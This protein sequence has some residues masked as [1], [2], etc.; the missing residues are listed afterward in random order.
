MRCRLPL[1]KTYHLPLEGSALPSGGRSKKQGPGWARRKEGGREGGWESTHQRKKRHAGAH[2]RPANHKLQHPSRRRVNRPASSHPCA[3]HWPTLGHPGP[4]WATLDDPCPPT[5]PAR[6]Q[7]AHIT[8]PPKPCRLFAGGKGGERRK[9][10]NRR[11]GHC[12]GHFRGQWT[13]SSS[14]SSRRPRPRSE[15]KVLPRLF[16]CW[17]LLLAFAVGFRC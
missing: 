9:R 17:P 10:E 14:S 15:A 5:P 8:I 7:K 3:H 11:G 6:A 1:N 2:G 16:S 4:P 13:S 12:A